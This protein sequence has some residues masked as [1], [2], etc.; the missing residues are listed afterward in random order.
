MQATLTAI[1][2][3]LMRRHEPVAEPGE[4]LNRVVQAFFDY[5]AVPSNPGWLEG[6]RTKVCRA[7]RHA[8]LGRVSDTSC[9]GRASIGLSTATYGTVKSSIRTRGAVSRVA[10][11]GKS[12]MWQPD[13][14]GVGG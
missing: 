1:R 6:F 2:A 14:C 13:L 4:W 9:L 10:T 7:W 11:L 3:A 5:H 8:L 12:R